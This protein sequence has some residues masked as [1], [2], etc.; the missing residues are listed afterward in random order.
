MRNSLP[1]TAAMFAMLLVPALAEDRPKDAF[2]V[3]GTPLLKA[4]QTDTGDPLKI[5]RPTNRR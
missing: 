1:A 2:G 4:T 3:E 5:S